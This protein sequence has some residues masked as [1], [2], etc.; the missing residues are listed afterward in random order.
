MSNPK[1]NIE[2]LIAE[3]EMQFRDFRLTKIETRN[4][5]NEKEE[6]WY[7]RQLKGRKHLIKGNHDDKLLQNDRAMSF[8]CWHQR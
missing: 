3:K 2:K 7:L 6:Q 8:L 4:N 5:E 1:D